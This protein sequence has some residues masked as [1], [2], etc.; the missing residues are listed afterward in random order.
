MST[1]L[2][3]ALFAASVAIV[4]VVVGLLPLVYL[5]W[6]RLENLMRIADDLRTQAQVMMH[7]SDELIRNLNELSKRLTR[8]MDDVDQMVCTAR[9]WTER[10]D[11]LANA[12]GAIVEPPVFAA[13]RGTSLLRVGMK[14]FFKSLF[15]GGR[16]ETEA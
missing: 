2:Q 11:R 16:R 12:V 3:V 9:Q 13:A 1:A 4:L 6:Q 14:A 15:H 8:Q 5:A 7:D 10:A